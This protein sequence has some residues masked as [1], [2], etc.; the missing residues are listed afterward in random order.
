M[1]GFT[2]PRRNSHSGK[3]DSSR[4]SWQISYRSASEIHTSGISASVGA[5]Q[6]SRNSDVPLNENGHMPAQ[7]EMPTTELP[8][9]G[10]PVIKITRVLEH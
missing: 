8:A 9:L 5:E 2:I 4:N 1:T 10:D 6:N 3:H 7:S